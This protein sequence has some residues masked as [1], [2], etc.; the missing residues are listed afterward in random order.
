MDK[1]KEKFTDM[2]G[3]KMSEHG[4]E[5][6]RWTVI[7]LDHEEEKIYS[8]GRKAKLRYWLCECSCEK[9]AKKVIEE[10]SLKFGGSRSC[11]CRSREWAIEMGHRNKKTTEFDLS[12]E[13]G[14]GYC[15][16]TG[17]PFYFDKEDFNLIKD[18]AF[19]EHEPR[20]GYHCPM[21][22]NYPQ[23]AQKL[24]VFLGCK[25]YDHIDHNPFNNVRSNLRP[26]TQHQNT[27]NGKLGKNNTTGITGVQYCAVIPQKPW[28][29]RIMFNRKEIY[30]GCYATFEDA[31]KARLEAEKKYFGDFAPQKHLYAQ[32]GINEDKE[33]A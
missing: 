5:G 4:V 22:N 13:V 8:S 15:R 9:H 14:V 6:S 31:V 11:G 3:W 1:K 33:E 17:T 7:S 30:L 20:P 10:H 19:F 2:T 32:Y 26:C 28:R 25:G 18:L 23:G 27:C 12:G 24:W 29:A 21:A 16:N